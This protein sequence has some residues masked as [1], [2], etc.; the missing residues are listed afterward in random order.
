MFDVARIVGVFQD[1]E[2][3]ETIAVGIVNEPS[4]V[5]RDDALR[6]PCR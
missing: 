1:D 6:M 4:C 3:P 5:A 2:H